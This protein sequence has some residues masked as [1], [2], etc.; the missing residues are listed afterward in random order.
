M[1]FL[2]TMSR[3]C[4]CRLLH[5][6]WR[7]PPYTVCPCLPH[8][9][10][11]HW[12]EEAVVTRRQRKK[13]SPPSRTTR[14]FKPGPVPVCDSTVSQ[15]QIRGRLIW[16]TAMV[17][18]LSS[19]WRC[20]SSQIVPLQS[21]HE[22]VLIHFNDRHFGK[23][24]IFGRRIYIQGHFS[25]SIKMKKKERYSRNCSLVSSVSVEWKWEHAEVLLFE[26]KK[27]VLLH[28]TLRK[29]KVLFTALCRELVVCVG[30]L[31][32]HKPEQQNSSFH[33]SFHYESHDL[34]SYRPCLGLEILKNMSKWL[35]VTGPCNTVSSN[36][37]RGFK[38]ISQISLCTVCVLLTGLN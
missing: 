5:I 24:F 1:T 18:V 33:S 29:A 22:A 27:K 14:C 11:C 35:W 36:P 10:L 13:S 20:S 6:F 4:G 31:C 37:V 26:E 9:L 19:V 38:V 12:D 3:H 23:K 28:A 7:L 15:R 8:L 2:C 16:G 32:S 30:T 25:R 17:S 21:V 34:C